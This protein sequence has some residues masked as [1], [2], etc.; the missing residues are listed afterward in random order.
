MTSPLGGIA[1]GRTEVKGRNLVNDG[2][3]FS[4]MTM[5]PLMRIIATLGNGC[6]PSP[7]KIKAQIGAGGAGL[8]A[9]ETTLEA[10]RMHPLLGGVQGRGWGGSFWR[11]CVGEGT[12]PMLCRAHKVRKYKLVFLEVSF[13]NGW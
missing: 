9:A 1:N 7:G 2:G 13:R 8:C 3:R 5:N 11:Q 10:L 4:D 12:K 6:S